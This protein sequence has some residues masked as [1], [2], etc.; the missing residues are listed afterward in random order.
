MF[1]IIDKLTPFV[2]IPY[3]VV[4]LFIILYFAYLKYLIRKEIQNMPSAIHKID[5]NNLKKNLQIRSMVYNFILIISI[6]EFVTNI[7]IETNLIM[8]PSFEPIYGAWINLSNSC[9]VG[10]MNLVILTFRST[11]LYSRV[12]YVAFVLLSVVP[13][14]MALFYIIL[15]RMYLKVSYHEHIR[16]YVIYI[17]SQFVAK[18][19]LVCFV[20]T[21]YFGILLFLPFLLIDSVIYISVSQKFYALLKG[22]RN[23][24]SLHST[25]Y[26]Y[27]E[28]RRVVKRFFYAQLL[29]L[30]VFSSLLIVTVIQFIRVSVKV[31]TTCFISY[32]TLDF[33]PTMTF[34]DRIQDLIEQISFTGLLMELGLV[35]IVE[36]ILT[37]VYLAMTVDIIVKL[38][39]KRR[40]YNNTNFLL[41]RP[42]MEKYRNRL[43][44]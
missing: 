17:V 41:S 26:E 8:R 29:T 23:S 22:M 11:F 1:N 24:A 42:L 21:F 31:L 25:K 15:R 35:F 13:I 33:I 12:R 9:C 38:V 36:L 37:I 32:I 20:Q 5:V 3:M 44:K 40:R 43:L 6:I 2:I 7:V 14:L 34:S 28:K 18:S 16:K 30:I 10:D 39:R 19:V 4:A 27:F